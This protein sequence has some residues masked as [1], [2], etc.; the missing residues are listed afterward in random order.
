MAAGLGLGGIA[1]SIFGGG[2]DDDSSD[3]DSKRKK[4]HGSSRSFFE[5]DDYKKR[6]SSKASFFNLGN[7]S[8]SSFFGGF[9]MLSLSHLLPDQT[10]YKSH[11]LN[12]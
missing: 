9:G 8:R 11:R 10:L 3:S 1:A 4:R 2:S 6:S 5:G 7:G 12:D